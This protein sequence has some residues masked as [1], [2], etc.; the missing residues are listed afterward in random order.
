MLFL[1]EFLPI[2]IYFLLIILLIVGIILGVKA[3]KAIEKVEQVVD[4]VNKKVESL[5]G[6]FSVID[7]TTDKIVSLSD[8]LIDLIVNGFSKLFFKKKKVKKENMEEE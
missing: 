7:F 2:I 1:Q 5:N 3:I 8:K 6:F 4:D